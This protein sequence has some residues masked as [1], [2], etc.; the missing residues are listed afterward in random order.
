MVKYQGSKA[1]YAHRIEQVILR[2]GERFDLPLWDVC[3]GSGEFTAH[4][5]RTHMVDN[6]PWG[7]FWSVIHKHREE[8]KDH[9]SEWDATITEYDLWVRSLEGARVPNDPL[10]WALQFLALQRES[11][12]GKPIEVLGCTWRTPGLGKTTSRRKFLA[13]GFRA[14]EV[15]MN[16]VHEMDAN[17]L[18]VETPANIYIDPDY[19]GTTGYSTRQINI[20]AFLRRHRHC[21]V[22]VSHHKVIPQQCWNHIEEIT[23]SGNV[24]RNFANDTT[25]LVHVMLRKGHPKRKRGA[26]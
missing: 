24:R 19:E 18:T 15:L 2:A 13:A 4:V 6:G 21:N 23:I 9:L 20:P 22:F 11:F 1:K 17:N 7:F 10:E 14:C 3:C 25:E 5:G 26:I 12:N 16:N 8:F